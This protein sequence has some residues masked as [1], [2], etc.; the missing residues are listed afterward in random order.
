MPCSPRLREIPLTPLTRSLPRYS[1]AV[2]A[3]TGQF[4]DGEDYEMVEVGQEVP[5]GLTSASAWRATAWSPPAFPQRGDRL[6][7]SSAA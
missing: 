7:R 3:G 1:L 5:E 4:L 6:V 2:S